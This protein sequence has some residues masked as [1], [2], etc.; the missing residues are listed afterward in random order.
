MDKTDGEERLEM[1]WGSEGGLRM[2][3]QRK[4]REVERERSI[5]YKMCMRSSQRSI[6]DKLETRN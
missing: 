5:S 6:R 1:E 4:R 3:R 2:E